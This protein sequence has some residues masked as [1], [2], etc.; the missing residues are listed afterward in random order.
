MITSIGAMKTLLSVILTVA[1]VSA[2]SASA[3]ILYLVDSNSFPSQNWNTLSDYNTQPDGSGSTPTS[4]TSSDDVVVLGGRVIRAPNG[5]TST[6]PANSLLL[7]ENSQLN[8]DGLPDVTM[9]NFTTGGSGAGNIFVRDAGTTTLSI[10][11]WTV[12]AFTRVR[13]TNTGKIL[14][15]N[16][17]TLSGGNNILQLGEDA[18][19]TVNF[20][21]VDASGFGGTLRALRNTDFDNDL[22]LTS[23]LLDISSTG[24]ITLDQDL[25]VGALTIAGTN[26][27]IGSYDFTFLNTN[28]DTQFVDG[29]TGSIT[30]V[31]EPNTVGLVLSAILVGVWRN[32]SRSRLA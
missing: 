11:N 30:V 23:G 1:F 17:T 3:T 14:D 9:G 12:D 2:Q 10:T 32:R 8:L 4:I 29:G 18:N 15:L 16:V 13:L 26:L 20:S 6:F 19:N 27:G 24:R 28:F 31:P 21:V 5:A 7:D 22:N 25:S